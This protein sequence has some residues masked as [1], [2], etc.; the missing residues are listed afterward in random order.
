L[1][2]VAL[3][4]ATWGRPKWYIRRCEQI[5]ERAETVWS[6][7]TRQGSVWRA[8]IRGGHCRIPRLSRRSWWVPAVPLPQNCG[9]RGK[10]T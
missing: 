9:G 3:D 5:C 10:P 6:L 8:N 7:G 2:V 4:P 1:R